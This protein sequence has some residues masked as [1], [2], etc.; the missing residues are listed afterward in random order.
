M[1]TKKNKKRT[2]QYLCYKLVKKIIQIKPNEIRKYTPMNAPPLIMV[3]MDN[4]VDIYDVY[5][6]QWIQSISCAKM[7]PLN[8]QATLSMYC[9]DSDTKRLIF[10]SNPL[11]QDHSE[12]IIVLPNQMD[13]TTG[14]RQLVKRTKNQFQFKLSDENTKL[15]A[16]KMRDPTQRA[17]L[18]SGPV[19]STFKHVAH[20]GPEQV[21]SISKSLS[22]VKTDRTTSETE[23]TTT[24]SYKGETTLSRSD[25]N[26]S[27]NSS[28][29]DSSSSNIK[30]SYDL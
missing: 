20:V 1:A 17:S 12:H 15:L 26:R 16:N 10:L 30:K 8:Q 22:P 7:R 9:S 14:R 2:F 13:E 25:S 3:Y 28:D 29:F 5:S 27:E 21:G 4:N 11:N 24:S 19:L 23:P 18:I 6:G